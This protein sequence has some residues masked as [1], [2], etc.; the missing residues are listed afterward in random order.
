M[1][2]KKQIPE[3]IPGKPKN[4]EEVDIPES[5]L[6]E[7]VLK[8]INSTGEMSGKELSNRIC[9]PFGN[10]LKPLIDQLQDEKF[11]EIKGGGQFAEQ[12]DYAITKAGRERVQEIFEEDR[13][14]GPAPVSLKEYEEVTANFSV[15]AEQITRH[16][17]E[18]AF[19]GMIIKP[20]YLDV[21]GPAVNSGKSVFVYGSPGNGKTLIC[22]RVINAFSERVGIPHAIYAGEA[23]IKFYDA[24][25]HNVYEAPDGVIDT[26]WLV[27]DRPFVSVGGELTM[28]ELD[29]IYEP[30]VGFYEAPFQLKA[31][32]GVLLIDDFGRQAVA[33]EDLLN[34]WIM[35]LEKGEDFLT[36]HTGLKLAVP[37]ETLVFYSTNI[38]PAELVDEAFLRRL[39]YKIH[40]ENPEEE[41]FR[42]IFELETSELDMQV[43]PSALD[44]LI[45]NHYRETKRHFRRCHPRDLLEIID[46]YCAYQQSESRVTPALLDYAA[47]SYFPDNVI[48]DDL[49]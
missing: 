31:N 18:Q 30:A 25:Y 19:E 6:L 21:L 28:E 38:N 42:E 22:E 24:T 14:L 23:V 49:D 45:K 40:A 3:A 36:L 47:N 29:L 9:L 13:Y 7:L 44:Y 15:R 17:L 27:S 39:R 12:W 41:E 20:E 37:F 16:D 10:I 46:D 11:I 35:P 1:L 34:R 5:F 4:L 48:S 8:T 2:Q 33:P 32:T 43:E 26:R